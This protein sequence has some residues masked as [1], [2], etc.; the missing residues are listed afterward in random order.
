MDVGR[1]GFFRT[2]DSDVVLNR[3]DLSPATLFSPQAD[4]LEAVQVAV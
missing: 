2:D 1:G 3:R 4:H